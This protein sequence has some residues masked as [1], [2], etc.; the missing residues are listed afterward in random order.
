[1]EYQINK[2]SCVIIG[3]SAGA[4]NTISHILR[5][6]NS[7]FKLPI[8]IVQHLNN[9]TDYYFIEH[10]RNISRRDVVL[11]DNMADIKESAVYVAP[12]DYHLLVENK[13]LLVLSNDEKVRFSRPSIDVLF[14][15][16]ADVFTDSLISIIL[17][18]A[19]SDGAFGSVYVSKH[20]GHTIAQDPKEASFDEMP[21][22]AID[23]GH[24]DKVLTVNQIIELLN[25][26]SVRV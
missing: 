9:D 5:N 22:K 4:F 6:L 23:T 15:S 26:L 18:G 21:K 1:M 11:V 14:E 2:Y 16:A 7:S 13:S 8:I 25:N 12:A 3:G 10:Y 19:N 20:G 17:T 24:I